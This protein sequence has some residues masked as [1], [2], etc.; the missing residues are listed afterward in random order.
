MSE[1]DNTQRVWLPPTQNKPF[2]NPQTKREDYINRLHAIRVFIPEAPFMEIEQLRDY[3][4]EYEARHID[5]SMNAVKQKEIQGK[6]L[7]EG[8]KLALKEYRNWKR[9]REGKNPIT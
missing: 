7:S 4:K 1:F 8:E 9:K 5:D 3:V 6:K 2:N